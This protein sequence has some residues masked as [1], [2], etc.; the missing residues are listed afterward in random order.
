MGFL[1]TCDIAGM[2]S[3]IFVLKAGLSEIR[4]NVSWPVFG[5][6]WSK[7]EWGSSFFDGNKFLL[8]PRLMQLQ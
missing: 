8:T 3:E 6:D 2:V 4:I 5:V 7:A 1:P